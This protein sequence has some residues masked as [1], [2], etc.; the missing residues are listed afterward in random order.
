VWRHNVIDPVLFAEPDRCRTVTMTP[1]P[2]GRRNLR[3]PRQAGTFGASDGSDE[4]GLPES[5]SS[6]T[7]SAVGSEPDA[8]RRP[9]HRLRLATLTFTVIAAAVASGAGIGVLLT[10]DSPIGI[11]NPDPAAVPP[12]PVK[13]AAGLTPGAAP[14]LVPVAGTLPAPATSV[15]PDASLLPAR[16]PASAWRLRLPVSS[17]NDTGVLVALTLD[18]PNTCQGFSGPLP[19]LVS[20]ADGR[21]GEIPAR[22][23]TP[24]TVAVL[25]TPRLT[26]SQHG[27]RLEAQPL[28]PMAGPPPVTYA[29]EVSTDGL[30]TT[31]C[32]SRSPDQ[33]VDQPSARPGSR[34][35]RVTAFLGN[36]WRRSSAPVHWDEVS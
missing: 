4:P 8:V 10:S 36:N 35:L 29:V 32:T 28:P 9:L 21:P 2:R 30:W 26:V 24:V 7:T 16:C 25:G 18:A 20:V 34:E 12:A 5:S 1:L 27:D 17:D 19:L 23:A 14:V 33:C 15:A 11:L 13:G 31:L 6:F 3:P 22:T